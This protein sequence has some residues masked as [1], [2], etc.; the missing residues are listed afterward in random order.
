MLTGPPPFTMHFDFRLLLRRTFAEL[1]RT[2]LHPQ[3]PAAGTF[4]FWHKL[5]LGSASNHVLQAAS[6]TFGSS[7]AFGTLLLPEPRAARGGSPF[8]IT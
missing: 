3:A 4:W 2:H 8:E 7:A 5:M 6:L 1:S